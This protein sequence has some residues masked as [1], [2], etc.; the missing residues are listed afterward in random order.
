MLHKVVRCQEIRLH[1]LHMHLFN[2]SMLHAVARS[3]KIG[4]HN[5]FNPRVL[6]KE[7]VLTVLRR[8]VFMI[9]SFTN[10]PEVW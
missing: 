4:L 7:K 5:L 9:H 2:P 8:F 1:T 10:T 6:S 3:Q